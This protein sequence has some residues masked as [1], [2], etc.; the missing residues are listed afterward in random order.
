MKI[1]YLAPRILQTLIWIPARLV[2]V[3]FTHIKIKGKDNLKGLGKGVIFAS[4]HASEVDPL[5][6]PAVLN[7][8][9][10]LFPMFYVSRNKDFYDT[11]GWRQ[12]IYGGLFFALWGAYP[13][14]SGRRNY[15]EALKHHIQILNKRKSIHI[16]PEGGK[17]KTGDITDRAH[18]GAAFLSWKSGV[19]IIP[20]F[21]GGT[22]N[23]TMKGFFTGKKK[24]S[25]SFG[26]PLNPEDLFNDLNKEPTVEEYKEAV[27]IVMREV[28]ELNKKV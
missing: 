4:N 28:R 11:S 5:L 17:S 20:V 16:F 23:T 6:I 19:P 7:L 22:F 9:S 21:I 24:Y 13:A 14:Y 25:I 10:K 18:A 3:L 27:K 2:F 26:K 1:H 12:K 15:E 8:F